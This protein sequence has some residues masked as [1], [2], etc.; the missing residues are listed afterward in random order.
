MKYNINKRSQINKHD[1]ACEKISK[2]LLCKFRNVAEPSKNWYTSNI[3]STLYN[4][5]FISRNNEQFTKRLNITLRI[6]EYPKTNNNSNYDEQCQNE[7]I[8]NDK[9]YIIDMTIVLDQ[10]LNV[11]FTNKITMF[12]NL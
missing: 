11:S 12:I 8:E 2:A 4:K 9:W 5:K 10:N 3:V 6:R 1:W 7:Q